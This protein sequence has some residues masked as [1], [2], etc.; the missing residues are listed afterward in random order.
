M[1]DFY[2]TKTTIPLLLFFIFL[3]VLFVAIYFR[4]YAFAP[5]WNHRRMNLGLSFLS[6]VLIL[7]VAPNNNSDWFSYQEEVWTF[8]FNSY[9]QH[10][11][12]VYSYII[13]FVSRNYML[14]RIVVWGGAF[15]LTRWSFN[16][17]G[18]NQNVAVFFIITVFL[19]T[20][21]YA[22]AT[23]GMA[24]YTIGL[25]FILKP[26]KKS[27]TLSYLLALAFLFGAYSFHHSIL[28]LVLMTIAVFTPI[29]RPIVTIIALISLPA[30]GAFIYGHFDIADTLGS[31]DVSEKLRIYEEMERESWNLFG[32]IRY[33]IQYGAF[34]FPAIVNYILV[35]KNRDVLDKSYS[36]IS[37]IVV[38]TIIASSAFLFM[39]FENL[40]FTYRILFMTMIPTSILTVYLYQSKYMT[41]KFYMS[42]L[43]WGIMGTLFPLLYGMYYKG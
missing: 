23:M 8:S 21:N 14:F 3:Y 9:Q 34:Y 10:L 40:I 16:R 41:R 15:V 31:E 5:V 7:I 6:L 22:R 30:L 12:P 2:W 35:I 39:G 18:L 4:K 20:F 32:M 26:L 29:D 27:K 13:A 1:I 38:A 37:K 11:E 42:I 28:I 25:S 43:I 33:F 36:N 19:L 17:F 24:C